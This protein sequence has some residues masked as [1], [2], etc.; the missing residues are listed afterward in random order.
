MLP[1]CIRKNMAVFSKRQQIFQKSRFDDLKKRF[2][3]ES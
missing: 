3:N 2:K 1:Q